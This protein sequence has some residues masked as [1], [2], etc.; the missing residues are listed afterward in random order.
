[1][2]V[3]TKAAF[4]R[5]ITS[6]LPCFDARDQLRQAATHDQNGWDFWHEI[7]VPADVSQCLLHTLL[8][9]AL[10]TAGPTSEYN[11]LDRHCERSAASEVFVIGDVVQVE[12]FC[13]DP[14]KS[15]K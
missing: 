15:P 5:P 11:L 12:L 10:A 7:A 2:K 13:W 14:N 9:T 3:E 4:T 8:S 1:M 6:A